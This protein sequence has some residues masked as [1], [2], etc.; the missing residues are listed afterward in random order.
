[1]P[2]GAQ[3]IIR[4][5]ME[6]NTPSGLVAQIQD[7]FP[8]VTSKQIQHT[9][10]EMSEIFWKRK[11]LQM[12]SARELLKEYADAVDVFDITPPEGVEML[13]FGIKGIGPRLCPSAIE[14]AV[15]ATCEESDY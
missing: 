1:M 5:N 8:D 6:W 13:A 4:E 14:A 15:D 12:E 10:A 11:D 3:K 7:Q 9:W 2:E